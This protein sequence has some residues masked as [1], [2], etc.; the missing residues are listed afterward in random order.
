[1]TTQNF[2]AILTA[3]TKALTHRDSRRDVLAARIKQ[4]SELAMEVARV[5]SL[6]LGDAG[7]LRWRT[8]SA[9]VSQWANGYAV[10]EHE[11]DEYLALIT[12]AGEIRALGPVPSCSYFD[13]KNLQHQWGHTHD[14]ETGQRVRAATVSQ[15]KAVAKAL[16]AA[17][18]ELLSTC[19][20]QARAESATADEAASS[21]A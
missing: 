18:A 1:M 17:I 13:G 6:D 20:E 16:P 9:F 3:T 2:N 4:I 19:Q 5:E 21:L 14:V 10:F 15:L 12:C 11:G 8:P 7:E